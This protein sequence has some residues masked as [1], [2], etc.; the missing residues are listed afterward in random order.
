MSVH[1]PT[2]RMRNRVKPRSTAARP[3]RSV[4]KPRSEIVVESD[5]PIVEGVLDFERELL[6]PHIRGLV[7]D[8]FDVVSEQP[9]VGSDRDRGS[10][11]RP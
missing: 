4:A 1:T 6:L 2:L 8:L 5:L 10:A 3:S 9:G 7:E 11:T